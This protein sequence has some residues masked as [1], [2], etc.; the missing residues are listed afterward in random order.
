MARKRSTARSRRDNVYDFE[1]AFTA[2]RRAQE[3]GPKRKSWTTHDLKSVKPL[4]PT[5]REMF[6]DFFEGQHICAHGSAGTGKSF[7]AIYLAL[8]EVLNK[9]TPADKII[10]IRSAVTTRD[11]G[12]LPGT[13][14]EK[15]Q[16]FETPYKD[17]FADICGKVSTYEDMKAAGVV[18]FCT[19]A[20]VRGLTWD[21]AIVVVDE[22]QNMTWTEIDSIVTRVGQNT[23]LILCGDSRHQ[24]D[25][26]GKEKTGFAEMLAIIQRMKAFSEISFTHHDIVRSDFVKQWIVTRDELNL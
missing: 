19:S 22:V 15:N 23:R 11:Q 12:F 9:N 17:I 10:I 3:E 26:T 7:V 18:Q 16:P 4:T 5:Q 24:M 13:Q 8:A 6:H 20:H 1:D 25:L 2:N 14:E 21:N